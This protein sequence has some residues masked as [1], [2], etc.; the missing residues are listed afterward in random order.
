MR[1]RPL[2]AVPRYQLVL[3]A[4][5]LSLQLAWRWQEALPDVSAR[6]LSAP[7]SVNSVRLSSA[8]EPIAGAGLLA[9]RL[10]TFDN[11]PGLSLPFAALDY[12]VLRAWLARL[13]ELDSASRYP[14][15]MASHV[16]S[17]T[18]DRQR[19]EMML[20]FVYREFFVAPNRRW[21]YL[22]HA[23]LIAKHELHDLPLALRYARAIQKYATASSVPHWA[24][25][26]PIFILQ[27]MGQIEA[28]KIELGG[29]LATGSISDPQEK[30]FLSERY[31][32]LEKSL[33]KARQTR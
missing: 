19:R 17:Q 5:L 8:D 16:Y 14:L 7:P 29:L 27:D 3:A 18:P 1:E 21:S 22:A 12:R 15:L 25:E 9:L 6:A 23:A 13:L 2:S 20:D 32:E 28:A 4:V 30:H 26:M 11:Q 33:S 31:V 24:Q 10:Q